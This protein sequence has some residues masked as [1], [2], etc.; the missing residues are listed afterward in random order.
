GGNKARRLPSRVRKWGPCPSP[1]GLRATQSA[2][3]STSLIN[4][5]L[6]YPN[7]RIASAVL[8]S[9]PSV[10][11]VPVRTGGLPSRSAK[12]SA[13]QRTLTVSGPLTLSGLDGAVQWPSARSTIA[14][15]SPCQITLTWPVVRLIGC[16]DT[17]RIATSCSTP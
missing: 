8:T 10:A 13:S 3:Q 15:A 2:V 12:H 4:G 17:T 16:P 5:T 9:Q 1:G 7:S 6:G 11:S 14:L